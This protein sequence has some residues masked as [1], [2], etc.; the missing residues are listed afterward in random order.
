MSIL[1]NLRIR[2]VVLVSL[3][4]AGRKVIIRRVQRRALIIDRKKSI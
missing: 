3:I 4:M 2:I 1:G